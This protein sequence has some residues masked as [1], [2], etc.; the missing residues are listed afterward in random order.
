MRIHDVSLTISP[1]LVV[2]PGDP[3]IH[4]ERA[5]KIEEGANANSSIINM[6]VHSG[7][8]VDAPF[9]F[10]PGGKGI[11]QLDLDVL[12]GPAIVYDLSDRTN[13]I[14]AQ[15]LQ[16]LKIAK[17]TRRV[18]FKTRNSRYWADG[19]KEFHPDFVGVDLDGANY[20]V[21]FGIKLIGM[22]YL[23]V[24]PYKKSR[25]THEALLNKEII[26]VEGLN[27]SEI[28]PG[29]YQLYCFPLKL[30]G[31]DGAPARV[32]LVED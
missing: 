8:H 9:H 29:P 15:T 31:S 26:I 16:N 7:T 28:N 1:D 4:L 32:V 20:L 5:K 23:S 11:E 24:S 10:L 21:E 27:L 12:I 17:G 25:P 13:V 3:S 22:D 14:D 6:S 30:K 19:T 18:L 2:W